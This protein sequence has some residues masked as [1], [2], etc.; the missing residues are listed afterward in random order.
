MLIAS[1]CNNRTV[2]SHYEHVPIAGWE[3]NDTL[4]FHLKPVT[5]DGTYHE[6][7]AL[8]INDGY[9]F[10]SLSLIIKQTV[11][12]NGFVFR[13]TLNCTLIDNNGRVKGNGASIYQYSYHFNDIQLAEGDSVVVSV[14]H[15]MKR[16]ILPAISDVGLVVSRLP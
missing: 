14:R 13:D 10:Q 6:E 12:P 15:N 4:F 2:Y 11:Y 7:L 9:P 8:R 3:R 1:A 5:T 16:E